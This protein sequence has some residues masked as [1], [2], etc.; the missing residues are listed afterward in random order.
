MDL[1]EDIIKAAREKGIDPYNE[2]F[3]PSDL[4]LSASD[5]GSFSDHCSSEETISGKWVKDV[6]L[7]SV[8]L[9]LKRAPILFEK[10]RNTSKRVFKFEYDFWYRVSILKYIIIVFVFIL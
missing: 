2:P 1:K 7:N 8:I 4:G 3:K 5:Y 6:I 9:H 10:K